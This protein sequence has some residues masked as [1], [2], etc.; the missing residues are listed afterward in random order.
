MANHGEEVLEAYKDENFEGKPKYAVLQLATYSETAQEKAFRLLDEHEFV[1]DEYEMIYAHTGTTSLEGLYA[2]LNRGLH[3]DNYYGHSMSVRDVVLISEN[4]TDI[5][6][7]MCDA[8]GFTKV[9]G[10]DN[11]KWRSRLDKGLDIKKEFDLLR[12]N[13]LEESQRYIDIKNGYENIFAFLEENRAG[14]ENLH[15]VANAVHDFY[16]Q[17]DEAESPSAEEIED[18]ILMGEASQYIYDLQDYLDSFKGELSNNDVFTVHNLM[19]ELSAYSQVEE[20]NISLAVAVESTDDFSDYYFRTNMN[21]TT[22]DGREDYYRVVF[23]NDYGDVQPLTEQIFDTREE[24]KEWI[25]NTKGLY[26]ISYDDMVQRTDVLR[27]TD[28][29]IMERRKNFNAELER[30]SSAM[31]IVGWDLRLAQGQHT[32]WYMV[33][34]QDRV[35]ER[36]FDNFDSLQ[37]YLEGVIIENRETEVEFNS[38]VYGKDEAVAYS[39]AVQLDEFLYDANPYE[40]RDVVGYGNI[41]REE[42]VLKIRNDILKGN[43][44]DYIKDLHTYVS[45]SEDENY[46]T[47]GAKLMDELEYN[48][49]VVPIR[50]F[51][52]EDGSIAQGD[53]ISGLHI[54]RNSYGIGFADRTQIYNAVKDFEE[55]NNVP[56]PVIDEDGRYEDKDF[57]YGA[58]DKYV[59]MSHF[60]ELE[61]YKERLTNLGEHESVLYDLAQIYYAKVDGLSESDVDFMIEIANKEPYA[62]DKLSEVR[63][64]LGAGKDKE[65]IALIASKDYSTMDAINSNLHKTHNKEQHDILFKACDLSSAWCIGNLFWDAE[66]NGNVSMYDE[67]ARALAEISEDVHKFNSSLKEGE[68]QKRLDMM[69]FAEQLSG[70]VTDEEISLTAEEMKAV[71][72]I[73]KENGST[74]NSFSVIE[75]YIKQVRENAQVLERKENENAS[76][77]ETQIN[78]REEN[79]MSRSEETEK[80]SAKEKLALKLKEGVQATMDSTQFANWLE[81]QGKLYF[82]HYSF[83]NAMLTFVQ[84]PEA[85]YVC[86]YEKWKEYGRQVKAGAKGI[87]IFAPV[88]AKE[89]NGK[90]SLFGVIRKSCLEQM[91]KDSDLPYGHWQLGKSKMS[92]NMLKNNLWEVLVDGKVYKGN[93]TEEAFKNFL[94]RS[95]IG[96]VP[97]DTIA[98]TVFDVS[99]TTDSVEYLYVSKD[100]CKKSEWVLDESG[101]PI[102]DRTGKYKIYN[103]DERREKFNADLDMTIK[104][105]ETSKMQALY[106]SLKNISEKN[107]VPVTE[108]S[109][110]EDESLKSGARGYFMRGNSADDKGSIVISSDLSLTEKVKTLIHEIAHSDLHVDLDKLRNDMEL[111]EDE[112]I[113]REMKETQAEAVAYMTASTFGMKLDSYSFSYLASWSNGRDLENFEKSLNVIYSESQKLLR[114]IE[115]ELTQKGMTMTF[116]PIDKTPLSQDEKDTVI[117]NN[118][119]FVVEVARKNEIV[120]KSAF[121]A[122][123]ATSDTKLAKV[124]KEQIVKSNDIEKRITELNAK[125]DAFSKADTKEEQIKLQYQMKADMENISTVSKHISALSEEQIAISREN[126]KDDITRLYLDSPIKAIR[127]MAKEQDSLKGLSSLDLKFI[128]SS[129]YIHENFSDMIGKDN[130]GYAELAVKHLDNFKSAMSKSGTAV[131]INVCEHWGYTEKPIF[132]SGDMVHPR[133]ANKIVASAETQINKARKEASKN[134]GF[135]PS[136]RLTATVFSVQDDK[137]VSLKTNVA[138]GDG[139][140]KD[141][142]DHVSQVSGKGKEQS[143]LV[144][145]FNKALRERGEA[146]VLSAPVKEEA[147]I[148]DEVLVSDS[149][150]M[151]MDE[152]KD[153]LSVNHREDLNN[154]TNMEHEKNETEKE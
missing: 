8:F 72:E 107:N 92:F 131:E 53:E 38:F 56:L 30:F 145:N 74:H 52:H 81:K 130:K 142:A 6:S 59:A 83:N 70:A 1:A 69:W 143:L 116:E 90:G 133:L 50:E 111:S 17:S 110:S 80:M 139:N 43:V 11:D 46:R 113:S 136:H 117:A 63:K 96:K 132:S 101:K 27:N 77:V 44:S 35:T 138:I 10:F 16:E 7:Y 18:E 95:V 146:K 58:Y 28:S 128:A 115:S 31:K 14:R 150:G 104:E 79:K 75:G 103:S 36:D 20:K 61:Q 24:A 148:S 22:G 15:S 151:S 140:Q 49:K 3:P 105:E 45:E 127:K 94:D 154:D 108:R 126:A 37:N 33:D 13:N 114:D 9:D 47:I 55:A 87:S 26:E 91:K 51:F 68:W 40:Y 54:P 123:K 88:F 29:D 125:I 109:A 106:E 112:K 153:T 120:Q 129:P 100:S 2:R 121:S 25:D 57:L 23:T 97:T 32:F 98:V 102:V 19:G 99:D 152:W 85:S 73:C 149:H 119:A 93:M 39:L 78:H 86:G 41:A 34:N 64:M 21:N 65:E 76:K 89:Y 82:N 84:K 135:I 71:Y 141:L 147:V 60:S 5:K 48:M 66:R 42:N 137:L 118:K 134:D 122:L 62:Y 67:Q 4:G 144:D 124:L 12:E